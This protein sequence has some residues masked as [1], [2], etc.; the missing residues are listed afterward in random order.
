MK[1]LFEAIR[2][3]YD[4]SGMTEYLTDLYLT[5]A[6]VKSVFPYGVVQLVSGVTDDFASGSAFTE[7]NLVQFNLFD[8]APT[9]SRLLEVYAELIA[10]YDFA[11]LPVVGTTALSCVRET[12]LQTRI[13][14][15]WMINV[16]YRMKTRV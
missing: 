16:L 5:Q 6:D 1:T 11:A 7:N 15:V 13:E 4:G 2:S 9:M 14:N 10:T 8:D 12:V 3:L